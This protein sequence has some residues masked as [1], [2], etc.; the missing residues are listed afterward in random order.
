MD[1]CGCE[2]GGFGVMDGVSVMLFSLISCITLP[3]LDSMI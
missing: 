2:Y 3:T 1:G